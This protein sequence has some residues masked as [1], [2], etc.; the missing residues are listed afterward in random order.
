M[1]TFYKSLKPEKNSVI[2]KWKNL[3]ADIQSALDSQAFLYL[4]KNYCSQ[5][6]CTNCPQI[7]F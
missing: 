5:K 3:G 7:N 4:Y 2:K 1:Y 6:K